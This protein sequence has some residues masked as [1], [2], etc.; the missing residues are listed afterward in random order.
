MKNDK[1]IPSE[2]D[3][4]DYFAA[5]ALTGLCANYEIVKQKIKFHKNLCKKDNLEFDE[6]EIYMVFWLANSAY[7]HADAM[8]AERQRHEKNKDNTH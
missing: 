1:T 6:K 2:V 5:A 7:E 8:L 3:L 4:R